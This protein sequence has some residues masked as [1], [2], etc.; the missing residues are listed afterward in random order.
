VTA[1]GVAFGGISD[2]M[3]AIAR[4]VE[5]VRSYT[6]REYEFVERGLMQHSR[7]SG[8]ER[9]FDRVYVI[10]RHDLAPLRFVMLN[11]YE[12]TGDHLRTAWARDGAFDAV[13]INDPNGT[14]TS[15]ALEIAK[16][17]KIRVFKWREFLGRLNRA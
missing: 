16:D 2:L 10:H 5:N 8:L 15:G 1:R 17:L 7:A 6:R 14:A 4:D 9:K 11:E 13:L 12:L 3:S